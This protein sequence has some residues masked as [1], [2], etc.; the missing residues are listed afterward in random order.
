M[1]QND[2][3]IDLNGLTSEP[4]RPLIMPFHTTHCAANKQKPNDIN[5]SPSIKNLPDYAFSVLQSSHQ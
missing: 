5:D 1:S 3:A 4:K 2:P